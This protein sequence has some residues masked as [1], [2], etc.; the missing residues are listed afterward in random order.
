MKKVNRSEQFINRETSWLEFNRRVLHEGLDARNSLLERVKF[1]A[2]FSSNLDEFFMKRVGGLKRQIAARVTKKTP[3]GMTP[4][5]QLD[6]IRS[7]VVELVEKQRTCLLDDILPALK[8]H[9]IELLN[10]ADLSAGQKKYVN[11]Y[12]KKSVF[13]ILT[14]LGT[15]PGQPFPII[16]N[17]SL[18]LAIRLQRPKAKTYAY[19]RVKIPQ[20]RPR[21]V[22]TGIPHQFVPL[23]QIIAANLEYLFNGMEIIE[24]CPFRVT[25]NADI[26]RNEEEADDLLELIEEEL[27]HRKFAPVVRLEIADSASKPILNWLVRELGMMEEDVYQLKGPLGLPDLMNLASLDIPELK[28]KPWK[29]VTSPHLKSLEDKDAPRSI[30]N[31]LRKTDLLVHHPYDSFATSVLRFLQ[32]AAEDKR[33]LAIK[34]TLY[35]TAENSPIIKALARASENGK[36]VAVLVEIKARFDEA[37]NIQWVRMLEST[38]V[39]V[40]YGFPV[41]KTHTKTLLVVREEPDG[42]RRYFHIGTGNYHSKTCNL[43][44]DL[45]ILSCR[46]ELGEDLTDLFNFLTGHSQHNSYR[47]LLVAPVNMRRKFLKLIDREI[48]H[49]KQG[50]KGRIIAKM[51]SLEDPQLIEKMYDASNAG[52]QIDLIVRGICCLRPGLQ[53]ISENIRVISIVG[54]FLEHSRIFYFLNGGEEE[55]YLGSADWMP[56]NLDD[57]VEA[58]TPVEDKEICEEIRQ[59][60]EIMLNDNRKAWDLH[61]DGSYTQRKPA[62]NEKERATHDMLMERATAQSQMKVKG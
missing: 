7:L 43:Y 61:N 62:P 58:I 13:P 48:K 15:G 41:L 10:Y 29:P 32:E 36:Q 19:A 14:P 52:V 8:K 39:H 23:E 16:S 37:N 42:I 57:R 30:F 35:R 25:R 45:G 18:S 2:I 59:I 46:P 56:R 33:V 21:W 31:L 50:T 53:G 17:L 3:D 47:K 24:N 44:T 12:F 6:L 4:R 20:N 1:L 55:Y 5:Q 38:G 11:N 26:E 9:E 27:R 54:R 22:E 51:N 49:Q 60:L 28:D 40:T 34:Q